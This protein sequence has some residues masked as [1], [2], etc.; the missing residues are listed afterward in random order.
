MATK[1]T[2]RREANRAGR[3]RGAWGPPAEPLSG[4]IAWRV[5]DSNGIPFVIYTLSEVKPTPNASRANV[6]H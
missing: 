6:Q 5:E 2:P 1:M 3:G 4:M